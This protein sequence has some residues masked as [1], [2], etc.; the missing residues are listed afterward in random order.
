MEL[1][2]THNSA[3]TAQFLFAAL[4][5]SG[6]S[7][8]GEPPSSETASGWRHDLE[9]R[10]L[11]FSAS[12]TAEFLGNVRGGRG[13]GGVYDGLLLLN[14]DLDAEKLAGWPG[15]KLHAA[16]CNPQGP[17][18]STRFTGDLAD[19]SN[20]DAYDSLRL[21]EA[22]IEQSAFR[23]RLNL[24]IGFLAADTEFGTLDMAGPFINS[25]FGAA[26]ALTGNFPMSTY[27][28]STLGVR[29]RI[30]PASGWS[31]QFG[32]YD[33]NPAP[34]VFPDPSPRAAFSNE[35]N[36]WGSHFALRSD[37]G[38][39]LFAEI[40]YR[41]PAPPENATGPAPLG[42]CYKLGV[43]YHTDTFSA[44][45]DR[46][47]DQPTGR[48]VRGNEA[49]YASIEQEIWREPGTRADGL[50][51]FGRATRAPAG[52]NVYQSSYEFGLV[53]SGLWQSDARDRLSLGFSRLEV[54]HQARQG[55]QASLDYEAI[56]ECT[57][58]YQALSWCVV[59]PDLQW[60]IQPGGSGQTPDAL[61]AGLRLTVSF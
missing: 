50:G 22:W 39:M 49:V 37:E 27:P 1:P 11:T 9:E 19:V 23:D 16:L 20:I 21:Y 60:I 40:S 30:N 58:E 44:V 51:A 56:L 15:A 17:S 35:L 2:A 47:T 14:A 53:Y 31:V 10:G 8:A 25:A 6:W 34:G 24:R 57:Y 59:Q 54:G 5:A 61:V 52:R 29:L 18:L 45:S 32:A 43:V 42:A 3:R 36:H 41:T 28:Y 13:T 46:F 33:G 26:S 48:G 7:S 55:R 12:Y 4:L 38:A